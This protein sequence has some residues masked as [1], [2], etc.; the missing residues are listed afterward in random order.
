MYDVDLFLRQGFF[1]M[2]VDDTV[3]V[4]LSLF[5]W[6]KEFIHKVDLLHKVTTNW[7]HKVIEIIWCKAVG[8]PEWNVICTLWILAD[9]LESDNSDRSRSSDVHKNSSN[10]N[11]PF[12]EVS[13]SDMYFIS[14][15]FDMEN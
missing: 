9:W 6:M 13:R 8:N 3:A 7:A 1:H 15:L 11:Q 5:L 2:P 10:H 12:V 14:F 4:T